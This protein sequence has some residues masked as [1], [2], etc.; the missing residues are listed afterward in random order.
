MAVAPKFLGPDGTLRQ[1]YQFTTTLSDRFFTGTMDADTVDMQV[2]V[3]GAVF[4]SD[5][6]LITF[7]GTS[8]TIPNPSAYPNG[9]R[10]FQGDNLILVKSIISTGTATGTATVTA[11]L[12]TDKDLAV[13]VNAPTGIYI[14]QQD[15]T[16]QVFVDGLTEGDIQGYQFYASPSAGGGADGYFRINPII[17]LS[18]EVTENVRSLGSLDAD[19]DVATAAG[20]GAAADPLYVR[21]QSTQTDRLG[22][23]LQADFDES[24]EVPETADRVRVTT[25]VQTVEEVTQFSFVHD[26]QATLSSDDP[27]VPHS[28]LSAVPLED[29]LYYVVAAVYY[30][31]GTEIES[32]FS[33]EVAGFPLVVTPTVGAFPA[34]SRQQVTDAV[35]S[36]IFRSHP[37]MKVEP[38]SVI[39]DTFVDPFSTEAQRIRFVIQFLH[40]AQSF[41]TLI[42]IDDPTFSGVSIPVTQ[43]SYKQAIKQ[44]FY[45]ASDTDVQNLIDNAFDKLASNWGI[46]R[47][48]GTRARGEVTFSVSS[49]PSSEIPLPIGTSV[50]ASGTGFH[51][52][53]SATITT[54]GQGLGYNPITGK[55]YARAYIQADDIGAA[56]VVSSGQITALGNNL[57]GLQV[58][59]E[60]A[61]FGGQDRES[62]RALAVRAQGALASV[63][64]GT[65]QG[66]NFNAVDQAGVN[67]VQV[68]EAGNA[69]MMRDRNPLT[70]VH[71]GGKVDIWIRSTSGVGVA[72]VTDSFAFGFEIVEDIQ[73]IVVGIISDL[74]FKAIDP[75]LSV[76][77]PIIEMMDYPDAGL[78]FINA[79]QSYSFDLTDVSYPSYNEIQ[80]SS[81]YNDPTEHDLTDIFFGAYRYRTSSEYILSRQPPIEIKTLTGT[82]SGLISDTVY[83]L[84]QASDPLLLGRSSEAGDYIQVTEP[85]DPDT[86]DTIP[87]SEPVEVTGESHVILEG[88]EY[89]D[90]LGANPYTL[91]IFNND[92][93]V[94][95]YGPFNN[96]GTQD[97]RVIDG[98]ET[99]PM[100]IELTETSSI[101]LGQTVLFDY[102]HDENFVVDYTYSS[103]IGVTQN[104]IDAERHITADVLVKSAVEVP[105]DIIA[106]IVLQPRQTKGRVDILVKSNLAQLFGL[107]ALGDALYVS[108]VIRTLDQTVGVS[109]VITP[110]TKM[111]RGDGATTVREPLTVT[112]AADVTKLTAWSSPTVHSYIVEDDLEAATSDAGG[113]ETS[114]RGVFQDEVALLNSGTTP[115]AVGYP[116]RSAT[117]QAFIIGN[118]GINIQGYS[119]DA[120]LQ[121]LYPFASAAE[122]LTKRIE[123][124]ANRVVVT[125]APEDTPVNH[126]YTVTYTV[127]GDTGVQSID[128]GPVEY[129]V[130]GDYDFTYDS[131]TGTR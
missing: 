27:A 97:W 116:L 128:P 111:S 52:T 124:T 83:G 89:V 23:L 38:G 6:D 47:R 86:G 84:Y 54:V 19:A 131:E 33:P 39:R 127:D 49:Q 92:R 78:E 18:G 42:S 3:R 120:T 53:S 87:S 5:P 105:V 43:S 107:L 99:T 26:R 9:L 55:F 90:S 98:D 79:S 35:V 85:L 24:I 103:V 123:I 104:S 114:F 113:P 34:V 48:G 32:P 4:V 93:T 129:L 8:F 130:A 29:P 126:E 106:T 46:I 65:L 50:L 69:L 121:V 75:R 7:E 14:E 68:V 51:T 57:Y 31:N 11:T 81:S 115:N 109:H 2:S 88:I 125:V 73:F 58:A 21:V 37:Q 101:T 56:G 119:D 66:Y 17:I 91:Q 67:Q 77:N 12:S 112:V 110:L 71:V 117:G 13:S 15:S 25:V 118:G 94:E 40:D 74:R 82:V 108:D 36:S 63:D 41:A 10:L 95:Y 64:S 62:N 61:T 72:R 22:T 102:L 44:A 70:G 16:V 1:D 80:L 96:T 60:S 28:A 100:G 30:V 45:L 122:L 20:G 76:S 59:N